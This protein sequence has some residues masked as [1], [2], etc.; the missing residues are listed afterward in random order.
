MNDE[1]IKNPAK[2]MQGQKKDISN[3]VFL[4]LSVDSGRLTVVMGIKNPPPPPLEKR[5]S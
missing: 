4:Q 3:V 5:G 2:E 1:E